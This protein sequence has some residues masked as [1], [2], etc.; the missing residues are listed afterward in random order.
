MRRSDMRYASLGFLLGLVLAYPAW[1]A[2]G[3]FNPIPYR[4]VE[5]VEQQKTGNK[6]HLVVNFIKEP[7]C[8]LQDF[9]VLGERLGTFKPLKWQSSDGPQESYDKNAGINTMDVVI[10]IPETPVT[11][12]EIRTRHDCD[13]V[14]VEKTFLRLPL[15]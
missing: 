9:Q 14:V 10:T 11:S 15:E 4:E 13:G 5:V 1:I 12:I 7:D 8:R 2:S 3:V 6:L